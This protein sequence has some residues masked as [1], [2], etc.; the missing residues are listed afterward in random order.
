MKRVL[1]FLG[2]ELFVIIDTLPTRAAQY[3]LLPEN[4]LKNYLFSSKE[5]EVIFEENRPQP[6]N[7]VSPLS[8][9][10]DSSQQ[11]MCQFRYQVFNL[12]QNMEVMPEEVLN[13]RVTWIQQQL[14]AFPTT[15]TFFGRVLGR[16]VLKEIAF[17]KSQ[18]RGLLREDY[19]FSRG[20]SFFEEGGIINNASVVLFLASC[21]LS[22]PHSV[23]RQ[24][25]TSAY[26]SGK[27]KFLAYNEAQDCV[28]SAKAQ[29]LLA[30]FKAYPPSLS[31]H[32]ITYK[33]AA[34]L[35]KKTINS[36]DLPFNIKADAEVL[37]AYYKLRFEQIPN[38]ILTT[39]QAFAHLKS[40][41]AYPLLP[42]DNQKKAKFLIAICLSNNPA[43]IPHYKPLELRAIKC[44]HSLS[45]E[46]IAYIH[47]LLADYKLNCPQII[48][49]SIITYANAASDL[50]DSINSF[51]E[52]FYKAR[53]Q[54]FLA[55]YR[56]YHPTKVSNQI[57]SLKEAALGLKQA[58]T[59]N[60][61]PSTIRASAQ[62][63]LARYWCQDCTTAEEEQVKAYLQEAIQSGF[64]PLRD[65][66]WAQLLI[67]WIE[68][69]AVVKATGL[70]SKDEL[71]LLFPHKYNFY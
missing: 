29:V 8:L 30:Y 64:L 40:A 33:K 36:G 3:N 39:A 48:N 4:P 20:E 31:D 55:V 7:I 47:F 5:T 22:T 18:L 70:L 16:W 41:F 53:A 44:S 51:L 71:I 65:I 35:L 1:L 37:L 11:F 15:L 61:L 19:S 42:L 69:S 59:T 23:D 43:L 67:H 34:I 57:I 10:A 50:K 49:D 66:E 17:N 63:H 27:L 2:L 52:N 58:L 60:L 56:L 12:Y 38:N 45:L 68:Q 13:E 54:A 9:D 24:F 62:L 28:T 26:I 25:I 14:S 6:E 32:L 21:I 46:D